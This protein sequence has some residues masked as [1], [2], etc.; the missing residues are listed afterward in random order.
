[1]SLLE[2]LRTKSYGVRISIVVIVTI[3][4]ILPVF[5]I[6]L[7]SLS[8][9]LGGTINIQKQTAQ[10][11]SIQEEEDLPSLI[12]SLKASAGDIWNFFSSALTPPHG[13]EV[14]DN[15]RQAPEDT[16]NQ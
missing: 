6:W 9:E 14:P 8:N 5:F 16:S 11:S 15:T 1:M 13:E 3:L 2:K 4:I 12:K 10:Q 7:T